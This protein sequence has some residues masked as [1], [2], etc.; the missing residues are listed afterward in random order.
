MARGLNLQE[1]PDPGHAGE[2][3]WVEGKLVQIKTT[4]RLRPDGRLSFY[5]GKRGRFDRYTTIDAFAFVVI[6]LPG[7]HARMRIMEGSV[8]RSRWP[9]QTVNLHPSDFPSDVDLHLLEPVPVVTD[10]ML[11]EL[12]ALNG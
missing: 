10:A 9:G 7:L 11:K 2:D 6:N 1:S 5:A 12:I 3:C 4:G 8:V